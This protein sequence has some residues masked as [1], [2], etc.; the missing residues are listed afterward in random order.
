MSSHPDPG[1]REQEIQ[2][3]IQREFPSG[4]PAN[5]TKGQLLSARADATRSSAY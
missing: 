2:T 3:E 5:L 4:I 1:N